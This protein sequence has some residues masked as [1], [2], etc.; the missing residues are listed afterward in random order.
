MAEVLKSLTGFAK[1]AAGSANYVAGGTECTVNGARHAF[2]YTFC[3][4]RGTFDNAFHR[5][6]HAVHYSVS[7][8]ADAFSAGYNAGD[9]APDTGESRGC[10]T[11][12]IAQRAARTFNCA[13]GTLGGISRF[14]DGAEKGT[15]VLTDL[16]ADRIAERLRAF[17]REIFGNPERGLRRVSQPR[18]IAE[19]KTN[20]PANDVTGDVADLVRGTADRIA[21]LAA[22]RMAEFI[23]SGAD[24]VACRI[25]NGGGTAL[26]DIA[27]G[28]ECV[29]G[30]AADFVTDGAQRIARGTDRTVS[31]AVRHAGNIA[32]Q[33]L[34]NF[35]AVVAGLIEAGENSVMILVQYGI[36]P[37][38]ITQTVA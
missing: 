27:D 34:A 1:Q 20:D 26:G 25:A 18:R 3:R 9:C 31:T 29:A 11:N 2:N 6:K 38:L 13:N 16:A 32:S 33:A 24:H 23:D 12:G 36:L 19:R 10:A 35:A 30:I 8:F 7:R 14:A 22:D 4:S 21:G 5:S 17:L 28:A 37:G 15:D